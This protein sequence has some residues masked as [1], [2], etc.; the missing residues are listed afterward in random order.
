M[1][2]D[3]KKE[4]EFNRK[5]KSLR[6]EGGGAHRSDS[7]KI[8]REKRDLE[9]LSADRNSET[10]IMQSLKTEYETLKQ[11]LRN[12]L[13]KRQSSSYS[14]GT[15]RKI[16]KERESHSL[17]QEL[18]STRQEIARLERELQTIR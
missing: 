9:K 3:P 7:A 5:E 4:L 13:S 8:D 18:A 6:P 16:A 1:K 15:Q 17:E 2:D 11:K 14:S 12:M 10:K